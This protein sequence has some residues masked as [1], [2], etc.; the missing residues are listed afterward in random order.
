METK[1]TDRKTWQQLAEKFGQSNP[2]SLICNW[3]YK[4]AMKIT[5]MAVTLDVASWELAELM[6]KL[7]L[8]LRDGEEF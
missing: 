7:N 4:D 6:Q 1:A 5:D 3:Y 8:P 2:K